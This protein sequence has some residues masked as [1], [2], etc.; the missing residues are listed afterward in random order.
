M[1]QTPEELLIRSY[2]RGLGRL[3]NDL[4]KSCSE[5]L[6]RLPP[7]SEDVQGPCKDPIVAAPTL[8]AN[9]NV[10]ERYWSPKGVL[11][12]EFPDFMLFSFLSVLAPKTI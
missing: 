8:E 4:I 1:S 3:F 7:H 2:S 12:A 10:P 11:K 9:I 6:R 5:G